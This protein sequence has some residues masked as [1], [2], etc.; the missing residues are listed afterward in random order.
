MRALFLSLAMAGTSAMAGLDA[1]REAG[2]RPNLTTW[3]RVV[4]FAANP[5]STSRANGWSTSPDGDGQLPCKRVVN[6]RC[7]RT[8]SEPDCPPPDQMNA[9]VENRLRTIRGEIRELKRKASELEKVRTYV[10]K[11]LVGA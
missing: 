9:I 8:A 2:Q 7:N 6:A 11:R 5:W 4:S 10:Q 3:K 1:R